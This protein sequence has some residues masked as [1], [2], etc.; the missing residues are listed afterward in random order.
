MSRRPGSVFWALLALLAAGPA[1]GQGLFGM[2]GGDNKGG[3]GPLEVFADDGIEWLQEEQIFI[4]RGNARALRGGVDLR[5]D[6]LRAYYKKDG[7]RNDITRIDAEGNVRIV[8]ADEKAFGDKGVYDVEKGIL[9]LSGRKVRLVTPQDEITADRQIEYWEQRQL[10]V[11]RGNAFATREDKRLRADVLTAHFR[12][13]KDGK[14]RAHLVEAFDNVYIVT[15]D[16]T[17]LADRGVYNVE[18]GIATLTGS[19]KITRGPNQLNGC[20]AEVNMNT[21]VSRLLACPGGSGGGRVRGLL[22]PDKTEGARP[23]GG[24]KE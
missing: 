9:V 23:G 19:V 12:K 7:N 20:N 18:T 1:A 4:A 10:A 15:A 2:A 13:G 17:V 24:K 6:V 11:A 22:Q 21:G 3:D 16:E 14:S 8:S 5:A